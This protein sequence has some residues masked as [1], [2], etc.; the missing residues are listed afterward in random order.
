MKKNPNIY[1]NNN[2]NKTKKE[3]KTT[4]ILIYSRHKLPNYI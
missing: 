3:A 2:I 1:K 4:L